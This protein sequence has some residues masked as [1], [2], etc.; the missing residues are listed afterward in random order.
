MA[1]KQIDLVGTAGPGLLFGNEPA[2]SSGGSGGRPENECASAT[3]G[4][5]GAS[6]SVLNEMVRTKTGA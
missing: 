3:G 5:Y 6:H 2:V 4:H 1:K